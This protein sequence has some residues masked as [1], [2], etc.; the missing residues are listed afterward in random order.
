MDR[1]RCVR[2]GDSQLTPRL[3]RQNTRGGCVEPRQPFDFP[4]VKPIDNDY[5]ASK[6]CDPST[7]Y[8]RRRRQ[9]AAMAAAAEASAGSEASRASAA[10][11]AW[12]TV[13]G[14]RPPK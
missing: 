10:R 8:E 7:P 12:R 9:A 6:V 1:R 11:Q 5:G 2:S 4:R 13:A 14:S 3:G